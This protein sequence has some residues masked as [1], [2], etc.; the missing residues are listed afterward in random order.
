[1]VGGG[2]EGR[3]ERGEIRFEASNKNSV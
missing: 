1:M 2:G 3:N